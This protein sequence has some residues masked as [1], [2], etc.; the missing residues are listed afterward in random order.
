MRIE[1]FPRPRD[2]NGR[3]VH[4]SARLY[5][6][7]V[8]P[9]Q[10]YWVDQL[11]AMKIKWVKLLDDGGGSGIPLA[12]KLLA[13][14]IMPVIRIYMAELNPSTLGGRELDTVERYVAIGV[15]YFES[16]NEP[17]LPAE[18]RNNQM[19]DNWLDIVVDN[20]IRD[21][22][23]V[24]SRGGLLA[25]PA[26]GPGSRDNPVSMVVQKGRRDIFENG[27]WVA[28]HNYT[29]NHPLDYP[30][31]SVNQLGQPLTQAEYDAYARWQ[32]SHLTYDQ[33]VAMGIPLSR[34][35][36]FKYNRWAWDARSM[37]MVNQVRAANKRP[38]ST[39]YDDP[40]CFRGYQAA[41]DDPRRL[42][43]LRTGHQ[44]RRWAGGGLGRR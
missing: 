11:R 9:S 1:D 3:G 24:L 18:W 33:I 28:I 30:D 12:Q 10:D 21:A 5:H 20:F 17:D 14:D 8:Y 37:E 27:C 34:D 38:G 16:N 19:P 39:V 40:N 4:W 32:Y 23:A 15:R 6:D 7:A 22:D 44:H 31:D 43:L 36:Y 35:D 13:A 2:D 41:Q 25:L 29:L 42:G 26:M